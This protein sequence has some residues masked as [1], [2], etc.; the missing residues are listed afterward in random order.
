MWRVASG[1]YCKALWVSFRLTEYARCTLMTSRT[2]ESCPF[3]T[4][5]NSV[6]ITG[7]PSRLRQTRQG[8]FSRSKRSWV[9]IGWFVKILFVTGSLEAGKDGVGDYARL[10]A[11]ECVRQG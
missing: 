2:P 3:W 4:S 11:A 5:I 9:E 7:E 8:T 10:L 6:F 1:R